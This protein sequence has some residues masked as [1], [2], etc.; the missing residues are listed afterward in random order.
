MHVAQIL[1]IEA[2]SHE[3]AV[4]RVENKLTI[5]GL[6]PDWSDWHGEGAF[7]SGL[8]GR[9]AGDVFG[10]KHPQGSMRYEDDPELAEKVI[11]DFLSAR[12][13]EVKHCLEGLGNSFD[14]NT[15]VFNYNPEVEPE[16]NH[17]YFE[18]RMKLWQAKSILQIL[19]GE[20]NSSSGVYDMEEYT[21]E[22]RYFREK[23]ADPEKR[24]NQYLV[25]VDFHF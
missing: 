16:M 25:V 18:G 23:L 5:D 2:E 10:E 6:S 11:K 3:K 12:S 13:I 4:S 7:G 22:L 8:A 1:L 24:G 20:W 14:L 15:Y 17:E 19:S 21:A 9:W